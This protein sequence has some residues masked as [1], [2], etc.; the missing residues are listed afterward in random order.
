M[1]SAARKS[2]AARLL[3]AWLALTA[4]TLG[5]LALANLLPP[6]PGFTTIFIPAC[7]GMAVQ[8]VAVAGVA[9]RG[10]ESLGWIILLVPIALALLATL[11]FVVLFAIGIS[12]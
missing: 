7:V 2:V 10:A 11:A 6:H 8:G 3:L 12:G 1:S 5:M 9:R 4:A